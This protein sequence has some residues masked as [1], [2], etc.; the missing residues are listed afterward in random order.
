[1]KHISALIVETL[2][3]PAPI[4]AHEGKSS[5][6]VVANTNGVSHVARSFS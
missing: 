6:T 5:R 2:F 4:T 1:M 3:H